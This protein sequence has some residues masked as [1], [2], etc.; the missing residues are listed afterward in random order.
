MNTKLTILA[1]L[2]CC[3]T[4]SS[5]T[6][7]VSFSSVKQNLEYSQETNSFILKIKVENLTKY[8]SNQNINLELYSDL[9]NTDI[10]HEPTKKNGKD[11]I[12]VPNNY[13]KEIEIP[14]PINSKKIGK[15]SDIV[16]RLVK[17][18]INTNFSIGQG[19]HVV[20]L[21]K[22][23]ETPKAKIGITQDQSTTLN[24]NFTEDDKIEIPFKI[25]SEGYLPIEKDSLTITPKIKEVDDY[26]DKIEGYKIIGKES[27]H[28]ITFKKEDD[29][30]VYKSFIDKLSKNEK[31]TLELDKIEH[32]SKNDIGKD[33][34]SKSVEFKIKKDNTTKN[35]YS[36]Y[37]GTN[38]D[39]KD[40]FEATSFYAEIDAWLPQ[41][42]NDKWGIHAGIYKNNNSRTQEE[43]AGIADIY[44]VVNTTLDS[45]TIQN[46]RVHSV[47][48]VEI[49][50]FGLYFQ[51]LFKLINEKNFTG[52][53]AAH[54]EAIERNE[55]FTF[56]NND[57]I[58]LGESTISI[59]SLQANKLLLS[60]ILRKQD[61]TRRYIDGYYGLGF[62]MNYTNSKKNFSIFLNPVIG[63]G[64][65]GLVI[66]DGRD[67]DDGN[68][69]FGIF[70][71][72]L[73]EEDFG[74][75]LSGEIRKYFGAQQTPI[76][77]INLSKKIDLAGV[78]KTKKD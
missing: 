62:P 9:E 44:T 16:F 71:F 45:I 61:F 31:I 29:S 57:L 11:V 46:K 38:F 7:T 77:S 23:Q 75:K 20:V 17:K 41:L 34:K 27:T 40:R 12:I 6:T 60:R 32:K 24:I 58:A 35:R 55:K 54:F 59:D 74:I 14:I 25:K 39:L 78:F 51:V 64:N 15:T 67:I 30:K 68:K 42:I 43:F 8:D 69:F 22:K 63:Y 2:L 13:S 26:N 76:I 50:N 5:Q 4:V 65:P 1:F 47:P 56:Q 53:L 52:H 18:G 36:F 28:K 3:L 72:S 49:E 37:I 66:R 48:N 10:I 70:G 73:I 33:D 21:S 19:S